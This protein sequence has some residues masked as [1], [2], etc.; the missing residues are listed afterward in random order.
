MRERAWVEATP[1][2][3]RSNSERGKVGSEKVA[4]R[5][6]G[7]GS[8]EGIWQVR[9]ER[10]GDGAIRVVRCVRCGEKGNAGREVCH[11]AAA[12]A[13]L[14]S[15]AT[16][17]PSATR[18]MSRKPSTGCP[19]LVQV[20]VA[21]AFTVAVFIA[22]IGVIAIHATPRRCAAPLR[23]HSPSVLSCESFHSDT[24]AFAIP[25]STFLPNAASTSASMA[26]TSAEEE[27]S[28][29]KDLAVMPWSEV[30]WAA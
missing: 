24:P 15:V 13:A 4:S 1:S 20:A 29:R 26:S 27:T 19:L 5:S 23:A 3:P 12:V 16:P 30:S 21:V 8:G 14:A 7:C 2:V 17:R 11:V 18:H 25:I 6:S 10:A 22:V 28:H 9:Q